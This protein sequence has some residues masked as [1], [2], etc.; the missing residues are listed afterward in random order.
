MIYCEGQN[1]SRKD[2][3]MYHQQ[4]DDKHYP[5]IKDIPVHHLD[6]SID[7]K[8]TC[9]CDNNFAYYIAIDDQMMDILHNLFIDHY[10]PNNTDVICKYKAMWNNIKIILNNLI[11]Y[12]SDGEDEFLAI[13]ECTDNKLMCEKILK[14][15]EDLES[16]YNG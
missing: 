6:Y 16:K 10:D 2:T 4:Y 12:Y 7:K 14:I 15:I 9:G 1:C 8:Y 3:C 11:K 5:I 13:V